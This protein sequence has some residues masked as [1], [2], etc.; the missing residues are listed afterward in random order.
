MMKVGYQSGSCICS[1]LKEYMMS[2]ISD[3]SIFSCTQRFEV[4]CGAINPFGNIRECAEFIISQSFPTF[5]SSFIYLKLGSWGNFCYVT[6]VFK[7][8]I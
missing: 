4:S 8:Q 2:K 3:F 6:F 5:S 1:K 7:N